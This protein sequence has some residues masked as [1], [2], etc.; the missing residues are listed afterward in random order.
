[1]ARPC[2]YQPSAIFKT[3]AELT[4]LLIARPPQNVALAFRRASQK[5]LILARVLG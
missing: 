2:A 3:L 1:L 5:N 4:S